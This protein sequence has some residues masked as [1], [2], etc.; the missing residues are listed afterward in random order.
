VIATKNVALVRGDMRATALHG[1]RGIGELQDR[2]HV[3]TAGV[4]LQAGEG[5]GGLNEGIRALRCFVRPICWSAEPH[6]KAF[7][8]Q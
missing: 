8:R 1:D 3:T 7:I 2:Y 4:A 6:C 5:V